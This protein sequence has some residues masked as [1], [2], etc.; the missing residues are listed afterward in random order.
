MI[1][2]HTTKEIDD[3]H[4]LRSKAQV[5]L[6]SSRSTPRF[7]H[8]WQDIVNI[9]LEELSEAVHLGRKIHFTDYI[10]RRLTAF[11]SNNFE[12]RPW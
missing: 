3:N 1:I 8:G 2:I 5:T 7:W 6:Q 12:F 4:H 10:E 11:K 9:F